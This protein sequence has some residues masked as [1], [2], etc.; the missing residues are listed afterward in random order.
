MVDKKRERKRN[1]EGVGVPVQVGNT[2]KS[3]DPVDPFSP[4]AHFPH[5]SLSPQEGEKE[6]R[7][8]RKR[9]NGVTKLTR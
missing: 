1:A 7:T 2:N 9:E 8:E 3:K 4:C 5:V 6:R